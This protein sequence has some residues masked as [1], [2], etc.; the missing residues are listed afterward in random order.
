MNVQELI[1]GFNERAQEIKDLI[2]SI[3]T[4][5]GLRKE[6]SRQLQCTDKWEEDVSKD[7]RTAIKM[8]FVQ[9]KIRQQELSSL[10]KKEVK[11]IDPPQY[12][13]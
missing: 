9:L 3:D 6:D 1:Q 13:E 11:L 8:L 5:R 7:Q 2:N 4:L 10:G 12:I